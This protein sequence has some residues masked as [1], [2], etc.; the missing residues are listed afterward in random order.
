MIER[1]KFIKP[2]IA[3]MAAH[4]FSLSSRARDCLRTEPDLALDLVMELQRA[5]VR[6][7]ETHPAV[8]LCASGHAADHTRGSEQPPR[9]GRAAEKAHHRGR[10]A[11]LM[12]GV[13]G[14]L[15]RLSP[16]AALL[17]LVV[18]PAQSAPLSQFD[19]RWSVLVVTDRGDCSIYRY[20]VIVDHG[21]ARY[22]G[23]ADFIVN[24][25][26]APNGTVRASI[27]RGSNHA[28]IRGRLGPGTG[29]GLWRSAGSYDCSGHWTAERRTGLASEEE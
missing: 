7:A 15:T 3:M 26:I 6:L 22:A 28:D 23:G 11:G 25:S 4:Y 10:P 29:S 20:G 19:G 5:K 8:D 2:G 12:R 17:W 16:L 24:G 27:S 1:R 13:I 9:T 18:A 21:Q 14:T